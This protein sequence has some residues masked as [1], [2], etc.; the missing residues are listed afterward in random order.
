MYVQ[1]K[2]WEATV[3][4]PEIQ[5]F[6]G[7]LQGHRARKGVFITTSTFSAEAREFAERIDSRIVL[8]DG[9]ML[10]GLMV[11]HDVGVSK[12]QTYEVKRVDSDYFLEE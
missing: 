7:V 9:E 4:R 12:T 3:G 2:R 1:A 11:E 5:K 10:A 6:A 8:M